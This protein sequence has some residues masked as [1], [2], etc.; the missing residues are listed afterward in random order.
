MGWASLLIALPQIM[1]FF[2]K[3]NTMLTPKSNSFA[4]LDAMQQQQKQAMSTKGTP[5]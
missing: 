4:V 5:S 3:N 1:G 2:Q